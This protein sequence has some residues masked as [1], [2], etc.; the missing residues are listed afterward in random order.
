MDKPMIQE[1]K[2]KLARRSDRKLE[3]AT[4]DR[5]T[6]LVL[7]ADLYLTEGNVESARARLIEALNLLPLGDRKRSVVRY[8]LGLVELEAEQYEEALAHFSEAR[9]AYEKAGLQDRARACR[10]GRIMAKFG[11]G[12]WEDTLADLV[13][14]RAEYE[15]AG[16]DDFASW[17]THLAHALQ[18]E[19]PEQDVVRIT[20]ARP[21]GKSRLPEEDILSRLLIK[22]RALENVS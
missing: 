3:E 19:L 15:E 1:E 22:L 8:R 7:E 21:T 4:M 10:W 20:R 9:R 6:D 5:I 16:L 12:Q 18:A 13:S 14:L 2:S 11:L 17:V